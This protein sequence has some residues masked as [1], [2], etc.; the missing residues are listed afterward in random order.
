MMVVLVG[1]FGGSIATGAGEANTTAGGSVEGPRRLGLRC[2][3]ASDGWPAGLGVIEV[4]ACH[5]P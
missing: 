5:V 1:C 4:A 2:R 3:A